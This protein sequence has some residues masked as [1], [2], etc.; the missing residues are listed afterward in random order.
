MKVLFD[1]R[2]MLHSQMTGVERYA[3][4]VYRAMKKL[5][6]KL[7]LALP[8][9]N[10]PYFHHLWEHSIL[11]EKARDY[12]ILFSPGNTCSLWVPKNCKIITVLHDL[13]FKNCKEAYSKSY[14]YYRLLT[15]KRVADISSIIVTISESEREEITKALPHCQDKIRVIHN[16]VEEK[17][18][19]SQKICEKEPYIL[20][21]GSLNTRKNVMGTIQAFL[22]I[23][24]KIP[25]SLLIVGAKQ[26]R[27]PF[28]QW[29]KHDRIHY[30]GF[31]D[32]KRLID[33]YQRASLFV[34]PS[35]YEGFGLPPLEAMAC[36][37]PTITSNISSLP[38]VVSDG[39]LTV[40]PYDITAL[41]GAILRVLTCPELARDL[42]K[43]G[44]ERAL[45]FTWQK[46]AQ[47]LYNIFQEIV[48]E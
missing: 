41:S 34:F 32:D 8:R 17:F 30:L 15:L 10:N 35:F 16:G 42:M 40:D 13:S 26:G 25:H 33:L 5:P 45:N 48:S 7:K 29:E 24:H 39:A 14:Y 38:E 27:F 9:T 28:A 4:C 1:G 44:R 36:F 46:N 23:A 22:A 47:K 12:D 20:S 18:L 37:C 21:V 6:I 11:P 2:I 19:N 43:R 3:N 31:V